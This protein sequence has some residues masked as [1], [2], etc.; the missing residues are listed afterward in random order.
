MMIRYRIRKFKTRRSDGSTQT[1]WAVYRR[2]LLIP[3]VVDVYSTRGKAA[4]RCRELNAERPRTPIGAKL[5]SKKH[6]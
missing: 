5:F 1:A 6:V 4:H 3:F 2:L